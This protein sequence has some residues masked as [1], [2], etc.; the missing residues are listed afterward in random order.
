MSA[1]INRFTVKHFLLEKYSKQATEKILSFFNFAHIMNF[2]E[3]CLTIDRFLFKEF[4]EK[5]KLAFQLLDINGD[6]KICINDTYEAIRN[7]GKYDF[8][9]ANDLMKIT[10]AINKKQRLYDITRKSADS[11]SYHQIIQQKIAKQEPMRGMYHSSS[12]Y[13]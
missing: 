13:E 7:L 12:R 1:R 4:I 9:I 10:K 8:L 2:E 11:N 6:D 5:L 3:Y